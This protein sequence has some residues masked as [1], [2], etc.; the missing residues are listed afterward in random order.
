MVSFL[1]KVDIANYKLA[2]V[3]TVCVIVFWIVCIIFAI[4]QGLYL[5]Y[6]DVTKDTTIKIGVPDLDV[7]SLNQSFLW[8]INK[9]ELCTQPEK[10]NYWGSP[11]SRKYEGIECANLCE[12]GQLRPDCYDVSN[13]VQQTKPHDLLFVT[14]FEDE[15]LWGEKWGQTSDSQ[16][17]AM[18]G[19]DNLTLP[20]SMAESHK[21]WVAYDPGLIVA[22]MFVE[23]QFRWKDCVASATKRNCVQLHSS[24]EDMSI[25]V[26]DHKQDV[27]RV[28]KPPER[29]RLSLQEILSLSHESLDLDSIAPGAT[30]NYYPASDS[31]YP[32][33]PVLRTSGVNI[34]GKVECAADPFILHVKVKWD[35]GPVCLMSFT[36]FTGAWAGYPTVMGVDSSGLQRYRYLRGVRLYMVA[37]GHMSA[38]D[39]IM[40]V[41]IIIGMLI[42]QVIPRKLVGILAFHGLGLYSKM[43]TR[44][45]VARL[46]KPHTCK[47]AL[48]NLLS[49][50][51][52]FDSLKDPDYQ[53]ITKEVIAN[54]LTA[55]LVHK[56]TG[57]SSTREKTRLK[58]LVD[59]CHAAF[60]QRRASYP[61]WYRSLPLH[62][63][64]ILD[65]ISRGGEGVKKRV[66]ATIYDDE[67]AVDAS[68]F[69][70][71]SA[72]NE[73]VP[74]HM[75]FELIETIGQSG[76]WKRF[77]SDPEIVR[78]I[79]HAHESIYSDEKSEHRTF[80]AIHNIW[81]N[82][83]SRV[84][85]RD[86]ISQ[87]EHRVN[88]IEEQFED[89]DDE[90]GDFVTMRTSMSN[91][92]REEAQN[93][94][95]RRLSSQ[96]LDFSEEWTHTSTRDTVKTAMSRN[97]S[98]AG[99][100]SAFKGVDSLGS[101]V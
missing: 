20:A 61:P 10:Y 64:G 92:T 6:A 63:L 15:P 16:L 43:Y 35:K 37:Q 70:H 95:T 82:V 87:F 2:I 59:F 88:Q 5:E 65:Y 44:V 85:E 96:S 24:H 57:R 42:L 67:E 8:Y 73:M 45:A 48:A 62:C 94:L 51:V 84:D 74:F 4:N 22:D 39:P 9:S 72:I 28:F 38:I 66:M 13:L 30:T 46:N 60:K 21:R 29:I 12:I 75:F 17:W 50:S 101:W 68:E 49:T 53:G 36:A 33:G 90:D 25:V 27:Y 7:D 11:D 31:T 58:A 97:R 80:K 93:E 23:V 56:M 99:R 41:T 52:A 78:S 89:S 71:A 32:V 79:Q 76:C 91:P 19:E 77:W 54:R 40:V 14:H 69:S 83:G 26:V 86:Y 18:S 47:G 98:M 34:K 55:S 81:L 1:R 3:D 100:S